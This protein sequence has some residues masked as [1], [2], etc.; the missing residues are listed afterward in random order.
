M[1]VTSIANIHAKPSTRMTR[2]SPARGIQAIRSRRTPPSR[3]SGNIDATRTNAAPAINADH[4]DSALRA[5][6]GSSAATR[7]PANGSA[8]SSAS[9][10]GPALELRAQQGRR[11]LDDLL[12]QRTRFPLLERDGLRP[13]EIGFEDAELP[14]GEGDVDDVQVG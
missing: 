11:V 14:P 7:L 8:S 4:V 9:D 13:R 6:E 12:G 5:L 10:I 1:P 2:S 3:I